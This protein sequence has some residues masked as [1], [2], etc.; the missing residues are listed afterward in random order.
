MEPLK[1]SDAVLKNSV[2]ISSENPTVK[3]SY[4]LCEVL[5]S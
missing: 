5:V 2:D 4:K 1:A 3:G